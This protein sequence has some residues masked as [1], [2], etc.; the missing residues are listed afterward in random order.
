MSHDAPSLDTDDLRDVL[1]RSGKS[2]VELHARSGADG[3]FALEIP[4]VAQYQRPLREL[5]RIAVRIVGPVRGRLQRPISARTEG[6]YCAVDRVAHHHAQ[7][8]CVLLP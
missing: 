6:G 4:L 7:P 1:I 5:G 8:L 2:W 3:R